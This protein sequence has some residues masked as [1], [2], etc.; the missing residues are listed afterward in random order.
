[1]QPP[2]TAMDQNTVAKMMADAI[3]AN[4]AKHQRIANA[5]Q[6]LRAVGI[7]DIQ[8]ACDSA[9]EVLRLG[10]KSRG[11]DASL[12]TEGPALELLVKQVTS[13]SRPTRDR[14]PTV[15]MDSKDPLSFDA[16]YPGLRKRVG[17]A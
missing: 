1:M 4:D 9:E 15:A 5:R 10:L 2:N 13:Q 3:K 11:I 8:L 17:R 12:I 14:E 7:G 6:L 16:M